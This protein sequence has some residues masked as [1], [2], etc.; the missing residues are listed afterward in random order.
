MVALLAVDGT[1]AKESIRADL[2][3]KGSLVTP[4]N[5][6]RLS[7]L[8]RHSCPVACE[9]R[10]TFLVIYEFDHTGRVQGILQPF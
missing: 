3:A 9:R 7:R 6:L 5:I 8:M 1:N 10:D 2:P 4:K